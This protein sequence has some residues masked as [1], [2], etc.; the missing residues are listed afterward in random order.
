[1]D[2]SLTAK[3]VKRVSK[4]CRYTIVSIHWGGEREASPKAY[5]RKLARLIIDQGA[6]AVIGHHP[7]VLQNIEVYKGRPIFYSIG[8]FAFG[9]RP[10]GETQSGMVVRFLLSKTTRKIK[11]ELLALNVN[12]KLINYFPTFLTEEEV[13][14]LAE[15]LP[16]EQNCE[17]RGLVWSC[18]FH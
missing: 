2:F 18:S 10:A 13:D 17:K 6:D 3:H 9:S 7:H 1:M 12:N 5:Q 4:L 14:P 15:L 16:S 11:Y 8:N